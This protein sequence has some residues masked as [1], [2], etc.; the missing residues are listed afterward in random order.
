[1]SSVSLR[2]RRN[3]R[4]LAES[5]NEVFNSAGYEYVKIDTYI[6]VL[7]LTQKQ[8]K[9][10]PKALTDVAIEGSFR[11]ER[12]DYLGIY[13][14]LLA[15]FQGEFITFGPTTQLFHLIRSSEDPEAWGYLP[16]VSPDSIYEPNETSLIPPFHLHL[17]GNAGDPQVPPVLAN[18]ILVHSDLD[19][20]D[21][22]ALIGSMDLVVPGWSTLE[23]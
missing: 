15:S 3:F 13:A 7:N 23:C 10:H 14:D 20:E 2:L 18:V 19:Y 5:K 17:I 21:F 16:L 6:P 22:F 1:L 12:R 11:F 8:Q 4:E 9:Q